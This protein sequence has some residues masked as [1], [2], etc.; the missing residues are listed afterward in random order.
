MPQLDTVLK[1]LR[2]W[3]ILQALGIICA[4]IYVYL[5]AIHGGWLWDD[6]AEITANILLRTWQGLGKIW[7]STVELDYFPLKSTVQWFAWQCVGENPTFYHSLN[8]ITHIVSALLIWR[9]LVLLGVKHGWIGGVLFSIHPLS[10]ESVG[11]ISELKNTLSLNFLLL[12][13]REIIIFEESSDTRRSR[14]FSSLILFV[15][16]MLCKSSVVMFPAVVVL[17]YWYKRGKLTKRIITLSIP[18]YLVSLVLG[19]ITIWFQL[20][21]AIAGMVLPKVS[22]PLKLVHAGEVVLF[23]LSKSILP[24]NL[25]PM[26]PRLHDAAFVSNVYIAGVVLILSLVCFLLIRRCYVKAALFLVGS[27]VLNC[28]PVLGFIPMSYFKISEVADHFA[29]LPLVSVVCLIASGLSLFYESIR[30]KSLILKISYLVAA[31]VLFIWIIFTSHQ[32]AKI[33]ESS[34]SYWKYTLQMNPTAWGADYNLGWYYTSKPNHLLDA[35]HYYEKSLTVKPDFFEA[36]E[37]LAGILALMPGKMRESE[38]HFKKAIVCRPN[39]AEVHNNYGA[40]LMNEPSRLTEAVE[41]FKTAIDLRPSYAEAHDNLAIAFSNSRDFVYLALQES[42]IAARLDPTNPKI[43]GNYANMLSHISGRLEDALTQYEIAIKLSPDLAQTHFNYANKLISIPGRFEEGLKQYEVALKIKPDFAEAHNNLAL[44]LATLQARKEEALK[45]FEEAISLKPNYAEAHFNYAEALVNYPNR[46]SDAI[47][48]YVIAVE[49]RPDHYELYYKNAVL[50][51]K[52][53]RYPEALDA[54]T[55]LRKYD[56]Q[57][58]QAR[59]LYT[60]IMSVMVDH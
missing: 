26:Y 37:N 7:F 44:N 43:Q 38:S 39:D 60:K 2:F 25:S 34:E 22:L 59:E 57:S 56:P 49:L 24:I 20:N 9:I 13:F 11:W 23:Y 46:L 18:F 32:R 8:I 27:F 3:T 33:F 54:I 30:L 31:S 19:L 12:A 53:G 50:N 36:E 4:G 51:A 1:R 52:L 35:I 40:L 21:R 42:E 45:H 47:A 29:Y 17:F 5:P 58:V 41:Q 14:Y 15:A 6:S 16:A 10:Q 48:H 28:V 55:Q